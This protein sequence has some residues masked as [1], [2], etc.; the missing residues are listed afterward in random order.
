LCRLKHS[1]DIVIGPWSGA[2]GHSERLL[3]YTLSLN[4]RIGPKSTRANETQREIPAQPG[5]RVIV[6][7]CRTPFVPYG[8]SFFGKNYFVLARE[9]MGRTHLRV[10]GEVVITASLFRITKNLILR[11][12][13]EGMANHWTDA[14]RALLTVVETLFD[15]PEEAPPSVQS[16]QDRATVNALT[17]EKKGTL[18]GTLKRS[19]G[20]RLRRRRSSTSYTASTPTTN[21]HDPTMANRG[22]GVAISKGGTLTRTPTQATGLG[23]PFASL[24]P[25]AVPQA[26]E[27]VKT[28]ETVT[29]QADL[30]GLMNTYSTVGGVFNY[31]MDEPY[32][33]AAIMFIGIMSYFA[34]YFVMQCVRQ[35][36]CPRYVFFFGWPAVVC[37]SIANGAKHHTLQNQLDDHCILAIS[38]LG[39]RAQGPSSRGNNRNRPTAYI[40]GPASTRTQNKAHIVTP[41]R[42]IQTTFAR[43]YWGQR[44]CQ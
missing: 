26:I 9:S 27:R 23:F 29:R 43:G 17:L 12:A 20:S 19:S 2:E 32:G 1:S 24:T 25:A 42:P 5:C 21:A 8:E 3:E 38:N 33:V 35:L 44:P 4:M 34:H 37:A 14:S 39:A 15:E 10:Y 30:E 22:V 13:K 40:A 11:N 31:I 16:L 7:E 36:V 6:T 28:L 41:M 18:K